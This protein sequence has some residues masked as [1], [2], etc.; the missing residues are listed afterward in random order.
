MAYYLF[1]C[2]VWVCSAMTINAAQSSPF[3]YGDEFQKQISDHM[4]MKFED[5]YTYNHWSRNSMNGITGKASVDP[6]ADARIKDNTNRVEEQLQ[7]KPDAFFC[8]Q[9]INKSDTSNFKTTIESYNTNSG[10]PDKFKVICQR[11]GGESF[12]NCLIYN[13]KYYKV[14]Q[15]S[16]TNALE[17][18]GVS[19]K[20]NTTSGAQAGRYI[21][22][23]FQ[24]NT[25]GE[26]VAVIDA[27]LAW[28]PDANQLVNALN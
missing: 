1:V 14:I 25:S 3:V 13:E 10:S 19:Y 23:E 8:N 27:H 26:K 24:H 12:E 11:T 17:L 9:E 6:N 2:L 21:F 18:D 28:A 4:M 5:V 22:R 20:N 16:P 15:N 7:K